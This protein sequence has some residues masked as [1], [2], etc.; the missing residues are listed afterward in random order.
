MDWAE[1][2]H[3]FFKLIVHLVCVAKQIETKQINTMHGTQRIISTW[4]PADYQGTPTAPRL[5]RTLP[6]L[7]IVIDSNTKLNNFE[8]IIL[9]PKQAGLKSKLFNYGLCYI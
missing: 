8:F 7:S 3:N 4:T 6:Y 2:T 1:K 5:D 9:N